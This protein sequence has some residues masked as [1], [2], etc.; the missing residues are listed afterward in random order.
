MP[1][2]GQIVSLQKTQ[3]IPDDPQASSADSSSRVHNDTTDPNI[4]ERKISQAEHPAFTF[5][6]P[7]VRHTRC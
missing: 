3:V 7:A 4:G 6:K 5:F 2:V 1:A